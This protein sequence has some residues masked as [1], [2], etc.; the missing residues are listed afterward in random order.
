[1]CMAATQRHGRGDHARSKLRVDEADLAAANG[2]T[3]LAGERFVK[4][5]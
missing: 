4:D 2:V 1:M 3:G 5:R